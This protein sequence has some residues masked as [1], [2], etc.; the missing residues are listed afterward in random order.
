MLRIALLLAWFAVATPV[1]G[2]IG[3]GAGVSFVSALWSFLV[4]IVV[5]VGA[6]L[7]WPV[8]ILW[9]RLRGARQ[10]PPANEAANEAANEDVK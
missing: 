6:V 2:Y 1:L 4:A 7:A 3:P 10:T 9:R 8:R 5:V